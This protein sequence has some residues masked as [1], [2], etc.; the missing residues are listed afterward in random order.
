MNALVYI[1]YRS[2]LTPLRAC[3]KAGCTNSLYYSNMPDCWFINCCRFKYGRAWNTDKFGYCQIHLRGYTVFLFVIGLTAS[4]SDILFQNGR[5]QYAFH[6]AYKSRLYPD[7]WF[8]K[9]VCNEFYADVVSDAALSELEKDVWIYSWCR[10]DTYGFIFTAA[11]THFTSWN[12]VI[13][14]CVKETSYAVRCKEIDTG[15]GCSFCPAHYCKYLQNRRSSQQCCD[16]VV[17]RL[18]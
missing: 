1:L 7:L 5:C 15:V 11:F 3:K 2:F 14:L 9:A 13:F 10:M 18:S 8:C 12:D 4:L 16:V 6:S 17:Q